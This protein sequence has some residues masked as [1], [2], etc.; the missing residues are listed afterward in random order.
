MKTSTIVIKPSNTKPEYQKLFL[1]QVEKYILDV[2][3]QKNV[4]SI[5]EVSKK[6]VD[7]SNETILPITFICR[8][9]DFDLEQARIPDCDHTSSIVKH[10]FDKACAKVVKS[11]IGTHSEFMRGIWIDGLQYEPTYP[12]TG[13][14]LVKYVDVLVPHCFELNGSRIVFS[15]IKTKFVVTS[16]FMDCFI[17]PIYVKELQDFDSGTLDEKITKKLAKAILEN[18]KNYLD[19]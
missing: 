9:N 17:H 14:E 8:L 7:S 2:L 4:F 11:Q 3:T 16:S 12:V 19:F 15:D 13:D 5:T 1:K 10:L 18:L 6:W